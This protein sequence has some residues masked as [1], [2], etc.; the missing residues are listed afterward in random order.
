MQPVR[1]IEGARPPAGGNKEPSG[2]SVRARVRENQECLR[3]ETIFMLLCFICLVDVIQNILRF[4]SQRVGSY[5]GELCFAP[6]APEHAH[7]GQ[8]GALWPVRMS[9]SLSPM[10][11]VVL[12]SAPM[13][14]IRA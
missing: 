8:V 6:E 5:G 2:L 11:S 7:G 13:S 3:D 4:C 9:T 14:C 1:G 12:G 10:K